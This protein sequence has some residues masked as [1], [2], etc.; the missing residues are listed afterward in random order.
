MENSDWGGAGQIGPA[1]EIKATAKDRFEGL[2]NE[3]NA[4]GTLFGGQVLSQALNAAYQTVSDRPAHSLHAYFLRR[5]RVESP[6]TYG[7]ENTHEGRSFSTRR[8]TATQGDVTLFHMECSFHVAEPGFEHAVGPQLDLPH[9]DSL[10]NL[11]EILARH[12]DV[13]DPAVSEKLKAHA[14]MEIKPLNPAFLVRPHV[15]LVSGFWMRI[16]SAEN[17]P[18]PLQIC[19]LAYASD[20]WLGSTVL[21]RHGVA[22]DFRSVA[23]ASLDHAMW[24][25]APVRM[26]EWYFHE[27]ESPWAGGGRGLIRGR[28]FDLDGRLVASTAQEA[29]IRRLGPV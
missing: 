13:L 6:V 28:F 20:A 22:L 27:M 19:A 17:L 29:L 1:L 11:N 5:G 8:V 10:A 4:S 7:V 26:N 12:Q 2:R 3:R 15:Q 18:A 21:T 25:H 16:P 23:L 24:L 9:P 14:S